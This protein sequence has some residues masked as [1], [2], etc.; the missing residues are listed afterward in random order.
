[1]SIGREISTLRANYQGDGLGMALKYAAFRWMFSVHSRPVAWALNRLHPHP[2]LLEVEIS[3]ACDLRCT[4]CELS[5]GHKVWGQPA[6]VMTYDDIVRCLDEFPNLLWFDWTGIG[7]PLLHPRFLEIV[8][9]VKRRGLYVECFDHFGRWDE[10]V[11][12][13]ML[14]V[15]L[16][17]VQPSVDGAT[18]ETYESIRVGS[19]FDKVCN[20]LRYLFDQKEA[21]KA[22]LPIVDFHYIV[23]EAN[24]HEMPSFVRL[25]RELA[26]RQRVGIQFTEIL[27][28]FPGIQAKKVPITEKWMRVVFEVARKHDVQVWF[29]RNS[30]GRE[31]ADMR[32]CNAWYMPFVFVT[33]DVVPCCAQNER[34]DRQWQIARSMGNIFDKSFKEIWNGPAYTELRRKIRCGETPDYCVG[35]PV[36]KAEKDDGMDRAILSSDPS[37]G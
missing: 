27:N 12:D 18:K 25:A 16:N 37:M 24:I 3:T 4:M 19:D 28:E 36:F 7:E 2:R 14:D 5:L 26:G 22:P 11:T 8:T 10:E 33:G 1:M 32:K 9:E 31:K 30:E 23:Q 13:R 6:K 15:N 34:G 20:N 35:C 21:R 17:R 29:N